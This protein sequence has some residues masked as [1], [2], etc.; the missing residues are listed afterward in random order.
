MVSADYGTVITVTVTETNG[1]NPSASALSGGTSLVAGLAPAIAS[2]TITGTATVGQVLTAGATGVTGAPAPSASYQWNRAG[3]PISGAT[4]STY[5]LVSADYGTV[6][7][8]TVTATNSVGTSSASSAS[9]LVTTFTVR[10]PPA[11]APVTAPPIASITRPVTGI[12]RANEETSVHASIR[13]GDTTTLQVSVTIP[14]GAI[15][16][17]VNIWIAPSVTSSEAASGFVTIKVWATD[18]VDLPITNFDQPLVVDLGKVAVGATP[19]F[20]HDGILWTTIQLF[21]G[22]TLPDGIQEGYYVAADGATMILTRHLTYF[23]VKRIQVPLV[24]NVNATRIPLGAFASLS[25]T[26]GSGSGAGAYVTSTPA[27]CAVDGYGIV[28]ALKAGTCTV[29]ATKTGDGTYLNISSPPVE[30]T[31]V[32]LTPTA[33]PLTKVVKTIT[34]SGSGPLKLIQVKLG[35]AF[36]GKMFSLQ[37]RRAGTTKYMTLCVVKLNKA[38]M[39]RTWRW[40]IPRGATIRVLSSNR[41]LV[42]T[43][44]R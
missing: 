11:D 37:I 19:A 34:V 8:V 36:G 27:I 17:D 33:A 3:T 43:I 40:Q 6:I 21:S 22:T 9:N 26:G 15:S 41:T 20:S 29:S 39:V 35:S 25:T 13:T 10:P 32:D 24:L 14:P 1:V 31:F 5:T 44:V 16:R 38:G 30:L 23:G 42:A 28:T 7:S 4:S 18:S 12:A 2:A